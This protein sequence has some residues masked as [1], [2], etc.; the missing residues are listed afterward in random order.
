MNMRL[1]VKEFQHLGF[2]SGEKIYKAVGCSKCNGTGYKGRTVVYELLKLDSN[3]KSII[4]RSGISDELW[5]YCNEK[6][7]RFIY[8][9]L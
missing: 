1:L 2:N 5:E 4:A 8:G 7:F 6:K 9:E 3:H